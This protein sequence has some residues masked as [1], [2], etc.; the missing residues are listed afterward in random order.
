MERTL[1]TDTKMFTAKK[2]GVLSHSDSLE[3]IH[4]P[5]GTSHCRATWKRDELAERG[6][7]LRVCLS[8]CAHWKEWEKPG[9]LTAAIWTAASA[10]KWKAWSPEVW[11][12]GRAVYREYGGTYG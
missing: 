9:R 7:E 11:H 3:T 4:H 1:C 6:W 10:F 2:E 12:V 5:Q 8:C